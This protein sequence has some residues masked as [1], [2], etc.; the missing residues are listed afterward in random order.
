MGITRHYTEMHGNNWLP[1]I[2]Q[3]TVS[4]STHKGCWVKYDSLSFYRYWGVVN[5]W[6]IG[7]WQHLQKTLKTFIFYPTGWIWFHCG[8]F[9]IGIHHRA[10]DTSC[11]R[12]RQKIKL[13]AHLKKK[14]IY[15]LAFYFCRFCVVIRV[16][17]IHQRRPM[18]SDFEGFLYQI[19]SITLFSYLNSWERASITCTWEKIIYKQGRLRNSVRKV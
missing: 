6:F 4:Y 13:H 11:L 9:T 3:M 7:P 8:F 16:F 15:F 14:I 10:I 5:P 19:L 12:Y 2:N 18:T 1:P 17:F